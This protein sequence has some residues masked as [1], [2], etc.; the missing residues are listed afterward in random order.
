MGLIIANGLFGD[1]GDL[2]GAV[3]CKIKKEALKVKEIAL[4]GFRRIVS[5]RHV[6]TE[7]LEPRAEFICGFRFHRCLPGALLSAL[8]LSL[9]DDAS[10]ESASFPRRPL[11]CRAA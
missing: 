9:W 10:C 6:I 1:G 3:L 8:C 2:R 7:S 4:D 5:E 11:L